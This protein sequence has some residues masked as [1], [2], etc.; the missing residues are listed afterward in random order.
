MSMIAW[1]APGPTPTDVPPGAFLARAIVLAGD[2]SELV[3]HLNNVALMRWIDEVASLHGEVA[4]LARAA[5]LAQ[6]RM[7][8]V[9]RHEVDYQAEAFQGDVIA[10]ATWIA[11]HRRTT[12]VR[13]T[14]LWRVP[15]GT[16]IAR[17]ATTWVHLALDSR[18]PCRIAD[19][20]LT[21]LGL[22]PNAGA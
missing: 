12:A 17:A 13:N 10:L 11:S 8:F 19:A 22:P 7:W 18:R 1:S 21:A 5:L 6:G 14:V 4:G 16:V 3:P 2:L 15:D 9:A 20:D